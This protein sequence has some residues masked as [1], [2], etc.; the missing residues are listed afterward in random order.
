MIQNMS[1]YLPNERLMYDYTLDGRDTQSNN[2]CQP[3]SNIS[4]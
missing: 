4:S 1:I 2:N 3:V